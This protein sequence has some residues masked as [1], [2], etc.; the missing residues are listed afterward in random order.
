MVRKKIHLILLFCLLGFIA[1]SVIEYVESYCNDYLIE[2]DLLGEEEKESSEN[3][4]KESEN[5]EVTQ[6]NNPPLSSFNRLYKVLAY[7]TLIFDEGK[8]SEVSTPPPEIS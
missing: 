1:C 6:Y 8:F 7:K 2:V 5:K 4:E 3:E